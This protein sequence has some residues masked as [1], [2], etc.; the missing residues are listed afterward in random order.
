MTEQEF[1]RLMSDKVIKEIMEDIYRSPMFHCPQCKSENLNTHPGNN[2]YG[3]NQ[4]SEW[5]QCLD[6]GCNWY[7]VYNYSHF[8]IIKP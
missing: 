1:N 4:H 3:D 7:D 8:E 5:V 2:L 6:C